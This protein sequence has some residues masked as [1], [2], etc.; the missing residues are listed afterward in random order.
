MF[1]LEMQG[2]SPDGKLGTEA[3]RPP[4]ITIRAATSKAKM[5][6]AT[7]TF[8]FGRATRYQIKNEKKVVVSEGFIDADRT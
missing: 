3:V 1:W 4:F 5:L 6:G 8:Y 7:N 2:T